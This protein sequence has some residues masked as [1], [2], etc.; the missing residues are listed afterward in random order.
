MYC[1]DTDVIIDLFRG[2]KVIK[3]K[4][5][6]LCGL[7]AGFS[8]TPVTLCELYKGAFKAEKKEE[9]LELIE[10]FFKS[11]DFLEF[12]KE[13]CKTFGRLLNESAKKGRLVPEADLMIASLAI[14][15]NKLLVTRNIKHF[16]DIAGL[17]IEK[18]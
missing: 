8:M 6:Y 4:F 7:N 10:A 3:D 5:E 17:K 16:K 14:T 18:W 1:L 2:D 15:N 9:A 13:S 12:K 11:V